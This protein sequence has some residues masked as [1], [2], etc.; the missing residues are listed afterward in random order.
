M[1]SAPAPEAPTKRGPLTA[2]ASLLA[3]VVC[4]TLVVILFAFLIPF[5]FL[6]SSSS[7]SPP[8]VSTSSS[9]TGAGPN[10]RP[11]PI[12]L[13]AP[14][15]EYTLTDLSFWPNIQANDEF[16]ISS[17]P[18]NTPISAAYGVFADAT[19]G[20][21]SNTGISGLPV[22][23]LVRAQQL[24]QSIVFNTTDHVVVFLSGI[25]ELNSTMNFGALDASNTATQYTTYTSLNPSIPATIS[26][27]VTLPGGGWSLYDSGLGIYRMNV[28]ATLSGTLFRQLYI[29]NTRIPRAKSVGWPYP[30]AQLSKSTNTF[31][32]ASCSLPTLNSTTRAEVRVALQWGLFICQASITPQY[33]VTLDQTC[34]SNM[35]FFLAY[36]GN[37]TFKVLWVEN[38]L[39]LLI[40][41][42]YWVGPTT[43]NFIYWVPPSPSWLTLPVTIP[44][45]ITLLELDSTSNVAFFHLQL[46]YTGW[47]QPST[48]VGYATEQSDQI[49]LDQGSVVTLVPPSIHLFNADNIVFAGNTLTHLG[50]TGLHVDALSSNVLVWSNIF[51]DIS[52][53]A[54]RPGTT[55]KTG[56]AVTNVVVQDNEIHSVAVEYW[57]CCGIFQLFVVNGVIDHNSI[58]TTPY[59]AMSI[60]LAVS[61]PVST[62]SHT[63]VTNNKI[64]NHM[65]Y[66]TDGGGV[67]VHGATTSSTISMN[68]IGPQVYIWPLH[69]VDPSTDAPPIYIDNQSSGWLVT[70]DNVVSSNNTQ[71]HPLL[72]DATSG[73]VTFCCGG[74]SPT[75]SSSCPV[76]F[77]DPQT[78]AN[79]DPFKIATANQTLIT[80]NAGVRVSVQQRNPAPLNPIPSSCV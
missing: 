6:K 67:Y 24:A 72:I 51:T 61:T 8:T 43:D 69:E 66:L 47:T 20:S 29:N 9:S 77:A 41:P 17:T 14:L 16:A 10:V 31:S 53:S 11:T 52:C 25:F 27:G 28:G 21:D 48:T 19:V 12:P 3:L 1:L 62:W 57:N 34:Y 15:A 30:S 40:T 55:S 80:S 65:Q 2:G 5:V 7:S 79:F 22:K 70:N 4:G 63:T 35:Q 59:S 78:F 44:Q 46:S 71:G 75:Y 33:L 42:G 45:I 37:P 26:G 50:N 38:I 36:V 23:S 39:E 49:A 32:C 18:F 60:G 76:T 64:T 73:V 13:P 58:D 56:D 54:I 68:S 74:A